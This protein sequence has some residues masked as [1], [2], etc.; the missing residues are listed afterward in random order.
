MSLFSNPVRPDSSIE[1]GTVLQVDSVRS[2]CKVKTIQGQILLDTQWL[3]PSG[4]SGRGSDRIT[5]SLGD[6][7]MLNYGLGYPVIIG[8][9]P[10]LQSSGEAFPLPIG[11]GNPPIDDGTFASELG[12]SGDKNKSKDFI[13]GDRVI[14]SP[15]GSLLALLRGGAALLRAGKSAEIFLSNFN[16]LVRIVSRNWSHFTDVSSDYIRNF[17]GRIYRYVGYS[18]VFSESKNEDYK[19]HFY[20]GDVKAAEA[21]KTHADTF[22]GSISTDALI[23]KE[24]V[25]RTTPPLEFMKRTLTDTGEQELVI[26]NDS[27]FTRITNTAEQVTV[28]WNDQNIIVINE[29]QISVT[30]K[31]GATLVLNDTSITG[32][33]GAGVIQ[34]SDGSTVL[35][36]HSHS[37]TIT[38]GGVDIT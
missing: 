26:K 19:L 7:V 9:L 24:Q 12:T 29:A 5:P 34:I 28:T 2:T 30:H 36:N 38:S 8:F 20:Y 16:S 15:G 32:T 35:T 17:Q 23:Y 22:S 14:S 1:E 13:A 6:R 10:R 18:K 33:L 27:H 31:D 11:D 37:V 21:V 3:L 4:G 25:T